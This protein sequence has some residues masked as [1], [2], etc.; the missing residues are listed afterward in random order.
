MVPDRCT[1]VVGRRSNRNRRPTQRCLHPRHYRMEDR[2][3]ASQ[4]AHDRTKQAGGGDRRERLRLLAADL[5]SRAADGQSSNAPS[6]PVWSISDCPSPGGSTCSGHQRRPHPALRRP[7]DDGAKRRCGVYHLHRGCPPSL[8]FLVAPEAAGEWCGRPLNQYGQQRVRRG[9]GRVLY[10]CGPKP[11]RRRC[12]SDERY[13]RHRTVGMALA[14]SRSKPV[15]VSVRLPALCSDDDIADAIPTDASEKSVA[16]AL[17]DVGTDVARIW[18]QGRPT[19][20]ELKIELQVVPRVRA[21]CL[22]HVR[23]IPRGGQRRGALLPSPIRAHTPI[24]W[25]T[26]AGLARRWR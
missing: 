26:S 5:S 20:A 15:A 17:F 11:A 4:R 22:D 6:G 21:G 23:R 16:W 24:R 7:Y 25:S 3:Q 13:A 1:E 8:K 18:S 19:A 14:P 2:G 12:R 9:A 10:R